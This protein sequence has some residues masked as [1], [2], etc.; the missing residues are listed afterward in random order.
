MLVW[1]VVYFYFF[2]CFA[3]QRAS[4]RNLVG[5]ISHNFPFLFGSAFGLWPFCGVLSDGFVAGAHVQIRST[6]LLKKKCSLGTFGEQE[7]NGG[8]YCRQW[9]EG[10]LRPPLRLANPRSVLFTTIDRLAGT[11]NGNSLERGNDLHS[12]SGLAQTHA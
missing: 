11:V 6:L 3:E 7:S 8:Y 12:N 5:E 2:I 9:K 1:L 10:D 4:C